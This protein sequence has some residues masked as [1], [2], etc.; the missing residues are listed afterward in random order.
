MAG[1]SREAGERVT[2][3]TDGR[4][5]SPAQTPPKKAGRDDATRGRSWLGTLLGYAGRCRGKM[6]LSLLVSIASVGVGF[7]PFYAVFRIMAQAMEGELTWEGAVPWL[8]VAAAAYVASKVLFGVSTLL[9][10][11]SAYTI[12][13]TL[14]RD[15]IDK[16]MHASLG[17][18]QSKSIGSIKSVFINRIEAI[19]VPLAHMIPELTGSL[20]LAAGLAAW[21]VAIDG[22]MALASL[23]CVPVGLLAFASGLREF[24]AKYAA[25]MAESTRVNSVI[26]EYIEG[27]QV[28]KAFNQASDSYEKYAGAVRAFRDYTLD[29]FRATWVPMNLMASIMPTTLPGVLPV[30]L[31]LYV[32]GS[33]T[34]VELGMCVIL[35]LAIVDPITRFT[36]FVNEMKSMEYAVADAR[37][38]LDLPELREPAERARVSGS[39]VR[40]RDVR[41]AYETGDEVIYGVSLDVPAGAFVALVG[42][43][44]SGK[45]TLARLV[46]RHW[47]VCGGSV[48]VG[49]VDVRAMPLD[50]L[51]ELVSFVAQ[52]NY[53]FDV[54]IRE[55]IRLGRP[56]AT[57]EEVAQAARDACCDEFV[58][59][60][61]A[62][63][64]TP[65]GEAGGAL[66]GGER[67]RISLARAILKDAPI[68]VLDEATAFTDPENEDKIQRS[69]ARLCAGKT[70]VVIAHRLPTITGADLI[71]VVDDGRIVAQGTHEELLAQGGLYARMWAAGV[72]GS[73]GTRSG[74]SNPPCVA[75]HAASGLSLPGSR[76]TEA[77][78]GEEGGTRSAYSG[79][80]CVTGRAVAREDSDD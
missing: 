67:Q 66:S 1:S 41:F 36:T 47:D 50:Q 7:V 10:H 58:A 25:Y 22:R 33:L 20:L 56:N 28:V 8:L 69:I 65:A 30:G 9:S 70:L 76:T 72:A 39:D 71:A 64:D 78:P 14:R 37:E 24:N 3:P 38:F 45:S 27:I 74:G 11:I 46:A 61:R 43:S 32:G 52:D 5:A 54:S 12:L 6:V 15:F 35:A 80:S 79:S 13:E 44:G 59:R 60:L 68:V 51:S 16:L 77:R 63:Y 26:V 17:T 23:V 62:G 57:D 29:W 34:P 18:V 4:T 49:G 21:L 75:E 2:A 42:P 48:E 53:L 31:A 55:N 19:E 40:L 73:R